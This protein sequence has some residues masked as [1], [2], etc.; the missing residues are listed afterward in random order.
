[1]WSAN[2]E[3]FLRNMVAACLAGK[4][5]KDEFL[6][7]LRVVKQ[8]DLDEEELNDLLRLAGKIWDRAIKSEG[9]N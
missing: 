2:T 7:V 9:N 1:M 8:E 3:P 6:S 4:G 5:D